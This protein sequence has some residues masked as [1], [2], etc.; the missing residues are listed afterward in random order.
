[1]AAPSPLVA[2]ALLAVAGIAAT[3]LAPARRLAHAAR[4][5][6]IPAAV[7][8][9]AVGIVLGPVLGLIDHRLLAA[10]TPAMVLAAVWIAARAGSQVVMPVERTGSSRVTA[11]VDALAAW[12]VPAAALYAAGWFLP[13]SLAPAWD[14]RLPVIAALAA[15]V[16]LA[17]GADRRFGAIVALCAL[18]AALIAPLPHDKLLRLPRQV[19]WAAIGLA[20]IGLTVVLWGW[21][22]RRAS[23]P[24]SDAVAGLGIG[25]G[26]GLASGLSPLVVCALAAAALA[27]RSLPHAPEG[28]ARL[29]RSEAPAAAI[30][31]VTAGAQ[32]G[33]DAASIAIAALALSLWPLAR[34]FAVRGV[35]APERTLGLVLVLSYVWTTGRAGSEPLVTATALALLLTELPA[36]RA[37]AAR[38]R[39]TSG[40]GR[41]EVSA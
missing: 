34:R 10:A 31:W 37:D 26:I 5:L 15:A 25:A 11:T 33:G 28:W 17:A 41:V 27:R 9:Y 19:A 36:P 8:W 4:P 7:C 22:A 12:L 40:L 39:L 32:L 23:L 18:L 38:G 13:A 24:P 2:A 35:G 6:P 1:M 14:P 20:G 16:S 21:I 3:Y 30:L 29:T